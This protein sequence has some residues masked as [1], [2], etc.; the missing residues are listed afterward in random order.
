MKREIS[1]DQLYYLLKIYV[2]LNTVVTENCCYTE[3]LVLLIVS[4]YISKDNKELWEVNKH[5]TVAFSR[6]C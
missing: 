5:S 6:H 3:K 1:R 4:I 2:F